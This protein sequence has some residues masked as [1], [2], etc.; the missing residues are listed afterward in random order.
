[1]TINLLLAL[2]SEIKNC[3]PIRANPADFSFNDWGIVGYPTF[4]ELRLRLRYKAARQTIRRLRVSSAA[5][6]PPAMK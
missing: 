2:L 5:S 4:L 1:M 6:P 3:A